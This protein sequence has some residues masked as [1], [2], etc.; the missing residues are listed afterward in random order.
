[1]AVL[2]QEVALHW[3]SAPVGVI[4]SVKQECDVVDNVGYVLER[5]H[6]VSLHDIGGKVQCLLWCR[7]CPRVWLVDAVE[8]LWNQFSGQK[9]SVCVHCSMTLTVVGCKQLVGRLL[10]HCVAT[11]R[12][13]V[14]GECVLDGP[15]V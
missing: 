11:P 3:D 2:V 1:M 7:R 5:G 10:G 12:V 15:A 14:G 13:A 8:L 9:G 4:R 6:C